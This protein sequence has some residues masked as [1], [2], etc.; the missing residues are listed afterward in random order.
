M[1][2]IKHLTVNIKKVGDWYIATSPELPNLH[3]GDDNLEAVFKEVPA[4]AKLLLEMKSKKDVDKD[5]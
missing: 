2:N 1:N 3:V 4:V 5:A